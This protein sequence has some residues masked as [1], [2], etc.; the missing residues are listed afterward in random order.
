MPPFGLILNPV[1]QLV[2]FIVGFATQSLQV[3]FG[4]FAVFVV[5]LSLVSNPPS[6]AMETRE[7]AWTSG[8]AA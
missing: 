8:W 4:V 6:C 2:A 1:S 3:L 7:V 5:G